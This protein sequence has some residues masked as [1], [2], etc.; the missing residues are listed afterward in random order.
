MKKIVAIFLCMVMM[1]TMVPSFFASAATVPT[2]QDAAVV[3]AADGTDSSNKDTESIGNTI[4]GFIE[5]W[6]GLLKAILGQEVIQN[7]LPA[8][9]KV[10]FLV[11]PAEFFK[12]I[13]QI[14]NDITK[15]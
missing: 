2:Q 10:L 6:G 15:K 9:K 5:L 1:M 8:L 12:T 4:K 14:W 13:G 7:F 3:V 11:S